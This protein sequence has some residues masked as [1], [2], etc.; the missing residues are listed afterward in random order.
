MNENQPE[1]KKW[2]QQKRWY[3]GA[4]LAIIAFSALSNNQSNNSQAPITDTVPQVQG[5][6]SEQQTTV[7]NQ[8]LQVIEPST[9]P[10]IAPEKTTQ[11]VQ[12]NPSST[13]AP[14]KTVTPPQPA[15]QPKTYTNSA[16]NTVQ[17]P[18]YYDSRPAG[19]SAK[20]RDG[21]YSF[22]QS[23]RGTCSHHGGVAQWY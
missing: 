21:T 2:Y 12:Y 22:S 23:R 15:E 17:S 7:P 19:A 5:Q 11:E 1:Q 16:G 13:I 10:T 8:Q 3:F 14:E 18:T 6:I 4:L 9:S 20:C